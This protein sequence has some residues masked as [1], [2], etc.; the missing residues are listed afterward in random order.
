MA[1]NGT[2]LNINTAQGRANEAAL[3][4]VAESAK[5]LASSTLEQTGSQERAS[6]ALATG[7]QTH[8]ESLGAFGITGQAAENYADKLGLIPSSIKTTVAATTAQG[9]TDLDGFI[10]R[11]NGRVITVRQQLITEAIAAG[12]APGAAGAAYRA[13]GGPIS[14]P[15]TNTS[16]SILAYLSNGEHVITAR[17]V[18]AAGWHGAIMA[19]RREILAARGLPAFARGGSVGATGPPRYAAP[20]PQVVMVSQGGIRDVHAAISITLPPLVDPTVIGK[21]LG[22]QVGRYL[23]GSVG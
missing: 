10:T 9:Q 18:D 14:G 3:D 20:S 21:I 16:D 19:L 6:A 11:N 4:A 5:A 1:T 13:A 17:E 22:N 12:A 8:I 15:G 23:V 7:R 2:T